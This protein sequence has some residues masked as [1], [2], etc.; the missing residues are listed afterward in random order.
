ME[1][2]YEGVCEWFGSGGQSYGYIK[3]DLGQIYVHFKNIKP[4]NLRDS[5]FREIR[6]DDK[7]KFKVS[8]GFRNSGTQAT[9]VEILEYGGTDD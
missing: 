4:V 3:Y 2:Y 7:V 8:D 5:K 9:E 6:K 1:E